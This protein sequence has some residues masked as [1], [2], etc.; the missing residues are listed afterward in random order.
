MR[1]AKKLDLNSA[2]PMS[3]RALDQSKS[4]W[5]VEQVKWTSRASK[6]PESSLTWTRSPHVMGPDSVSSIYEK[7][8]TEL[9]PSYSRA[10]LWSVACCQVAEG[11]CHTSSCRGVQE[12]RAE[13]GVKEPD[14]GGHQVRS[15]GRLWRGRQVSIRKLKYQTPTPTVSSAVSIAAR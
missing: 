12:C 13:R 14:Q 8:R 10:P 15:F 11:T 5:R 1:S 6:E 4:Q 3:G 2:M 7:K 9:V